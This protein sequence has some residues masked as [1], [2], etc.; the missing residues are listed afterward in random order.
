MNTASSIL[1]ENRNVSTAT[2]SWQTLSHWP[3]TRRYV[4]SILGW[5]ILLMKR[6]THISVHTVTEDTP[7]VLMFVV[8]ARQSNVCNCIFVPVHILSFYNVSMSPALSESVLGIFVKASEQSSACKHSHF[9][10]CHSVAP[11]LLYHFI[12]V[13]A[14]CKC[15][16]LAIVSSIVSVSSLIQALSSIL[17]IVYMVQLVLFCILCP[18]NHM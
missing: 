13:C 17:Y 12:Y 9:T 1:L 11:S 7:A 15:I 3:T 18:C 2:G 14:S 16:S 8:T 10:I 5:R 6:G 4:R